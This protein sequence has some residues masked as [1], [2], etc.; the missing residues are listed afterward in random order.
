[1]IGSKNLGKSTNLTDIIGENK[2]E[3][4]VDGFQFT[5]GPVWKDGYLLFSDIPADTIYKYEEDA[6]PYL[7]PSGHS[8]GL[9]LD[10]QGRLLLCEHD[11]RLTRLEKD[12]SKT[13]LAEYYEGKRL[14]SP[15]DLVVKTDGSIYFTDPPYGLP[16]R[17]EGKELDFC[18][19]YR[20]D[21]D[22]TL[23]LLDDSIELPNGLA[24]SPNEKT[25][26]VADTSNAYVYAYDVTSGLENKRVFAKLGEAGRTG[27]A[28]GMK[29]DMD[30]NVFCT[31]PG[32]IHVLNPEGTRIGV[33]ECPEIPANI[34]WGGDDYKTLYITARTGLY[35]LKVLTGGASY[36]S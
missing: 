11:R 1:M 36:S 33:I 13:I 32:G 10:K 30:G 3:K 28:D 14:N 12:G 5:E 24:F 35:R 31:G 23:T 25:L 18:G 6:E 9:T 8:N 15:N 4:L 34:A 7:K 19:V 2:V 20:L 21:P 22:G 17:I 26:Y 29:V 16:N 27:S